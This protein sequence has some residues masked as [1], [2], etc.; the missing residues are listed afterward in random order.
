MLINT[1]NSLATALR[2]PNSNIKRLCKAFWS[3]PFFIYFG[4]R[5][6]YWLLFLYFRGRN[7]PTWPSGI[8]LSSKYLI[9]S[10]TL[11][12]GSCC[13]LFL[14]GEMG[15]F[16]SSLIFTRF[17]RSLSVIP[18]NSPLT[19][20]LRLLIILLVYIIFSSLLLTYSSHLFQPFLW[21]WSFSWKM[22]VA[23]GSQG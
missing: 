9:N 16:A 10:C 17:S 23:D 12:L 2:Q 4:S 21:A 6:W 3:P 14:G 8:G 11:L 20:S 13:R 15:R 18:D 5:R 1:Y 22:G 7:R 19:N